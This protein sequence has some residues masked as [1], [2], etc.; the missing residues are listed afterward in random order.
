MPRLHQVEIMFGLLRKEVNDF[1]NSLIGYIA[2]IV[3]IT[4]TGLF[5]WIFPGNFNVLDAGYANLETLFVIAP[6]VFMF[7][8]PAITMRSF[9]EENRAGTI[10]V[11]LTK[12][13]SDW[14]IILSKYGA[15][16]LL[17]IFAL[18]PTLVYFIS[19]FE[20]GA[21]KGNLDL[22][23]TF[24]SYIGLGMLA[25][26]FIAIGLFASSL[27]NN[28]IVSFI[29]GVFLSFLCYI[30]FD[31]LSELSV[32]D[33][34]GTLVIKLG[35]NEHYNSLSRGVIDTRDI[36]YFLSISCV[37]LFCTKTSMGSRKW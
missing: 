24:G 14:Q 16:L 30:G 27:S 7:L 22:G 9:S 29:L 23:G 3:F 12:P 2:L 28:Q 37:F 21:P 20:L 32:F 31:S 4:I 17:M 26:G 33:S 35:M 15:G 13:V 36:I 10:E 8:A 1:L 25:M 5:M 34:M 11:L 19:I 18:L 6:W